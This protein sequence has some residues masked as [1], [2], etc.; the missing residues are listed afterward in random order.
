MVASSLA[1]LAVSAMAFNVDWVAALT[2]STTSTSTVDGQEATI[3][4]ALP[5]QGSIIGGT[6]LGSS[7]QTFLPS[8]ATTTAAGTTTRGLGVLSEHNKLAITGAC[9]VN[10]AMHQKRCN[11]AVTYTTVTGDAVIGI[12]VRIATMNGEGT[13]TD[14]D[15]PLLIKNVPGQVFQY[16]GLLP[17]NPAQDVASFI[18]NVDAT[19]T[20]FVALTPDGLRAQDTF[21]S[22]TAIQ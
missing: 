20:L 1:F 13:F 16:S 8:L 10:T 2:A 6:L 3:T 15:G 7:T 21:A 4:Q 9:V 5:G 22:S 12:P 19:N 18:E 17:N 14:V 11:M